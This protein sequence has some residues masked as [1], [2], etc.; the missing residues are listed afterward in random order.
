MKSKIFETLI[1]LLGTLIFLSLI[2]PIFL[3]WIPLQIRLSSTDIYRFD[4]GICRY[5]GLAPIFLGAVVFIICS[6]SF[7]FVARGTP[8]P[9][10]PTKELIVTG[11]YSFV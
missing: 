3:N 2:I 5:L 8:I 11:I 4:I 1:A 6:G 7:V 10:T 9:F